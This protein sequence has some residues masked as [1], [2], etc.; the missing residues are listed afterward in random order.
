MQLL[1]ESALLTTESASHV[2]DTRVMC[3]RQYMPLDGS[4]DEEA[5]AVM[6]PKVPLPGIPA[7]RPT[8]AGPSEQQGEAASAASTP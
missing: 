5:P 3:R 6:D 1:S 4:P 7:H 2:T 8:S